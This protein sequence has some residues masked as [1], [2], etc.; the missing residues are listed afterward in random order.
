M[1]FR[2]MHYL[3]LELEDSVP[4]VPPISNLQG[5]ATPAPGTVFL[6]NRTGL[7]RADAQ[8]KTSPVELPQP[9][10]PHLLVEAP[11]DE[12]L[13]I[14]TLGDCLVL[15][16]E[17]HVKRRLSLGSNIA[18]AA[19]DE[20]GI[21]VLRGTGALDKFSYDGS[22][23]PDDE[24]V[25]RV[26]AVVQSREGTILLVPYDGSIWINLEDHFDDAGE[27]RL[28][29][30]PVRLFGEGRVSADLLAEEDL[31]VLTEAGK[32]VAVDD[33]GRAY[34]ARYDAKKVEQVLGRKLSAATD[35][36]ATRIEFHSVEEV[37]IL[38]SVRA[39]WLS[40]LATNRNRLLRFQ[41]Y[42]E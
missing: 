33:E 20:F 39:M 26:N 30:D 25:R 12:V 29:L 16:H 17:A 6:F 22:H 14:D 37:P 21:L 8:G 24:Q 7:F 18:D 27:P 35:C 28:R 15:D 19:T 10:E 2:P 38:R 3:W 4:L 32:I 31:I 42:T 41:I 1:G 11:R 9:F 5:F 34:P 40:V 13:L 36:I 23:I